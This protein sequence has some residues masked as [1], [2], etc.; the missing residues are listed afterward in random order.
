MSDM[1]SPKTDIR[2]RQ[3]WPSR[4]WG[5][6]RLLDKGERLRSLS[7]MVSS[8]VWIVGQLLTQGY[9][10]C[11]IAVLLQVRLSVVQSWQRQWRRML[12]RLGEHR[13]GLSLLHRE[14]KIFGG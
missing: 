6:G 3:E 14:E 11:D 10:P 12:K 9:K 5:G 7:E 13:S 4:V 1:Q 2:P 8:H